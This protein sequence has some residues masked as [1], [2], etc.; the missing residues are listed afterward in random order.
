MKSYFFRIII[1]SSN[2]HKGELNMK[3]LKLQ[4]FQRTYRLF[5]QCVRWEEN[6][7]RSEEDKLKAKAQYEEF[8]QF[9]KDSGLEQEYCDWRAQM[10]EEAMS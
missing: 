9:L 1:L 3:K 5:R 2:K 6:E 10:V 8:Y 4:L 7:Y